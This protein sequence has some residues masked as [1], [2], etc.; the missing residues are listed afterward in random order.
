VVNLAE[1][2]VK[3][4]IIG[5]KVHDVGYRI[6]L[7]EAAMDCGVMKISAYWW[8]EDSSQAVICLV[9]GDEERIAAFQNFVESHKPVKAEVSAI[10][11]EDYNGDV[12]RI[13]EFAQICTC[14]ILQKLFQ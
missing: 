6:F 12:M 13:G 3:A 10:A 4:K 11:W 2:S 7:M 5:P 1:R 8:E 9:E 14:R